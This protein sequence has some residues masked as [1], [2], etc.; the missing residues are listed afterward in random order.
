MRRRRVFVHGEWH[1]WIY[2]CQWQV[3]TVTRLVGHSALQS[4]AKRPILRAA[5]ELDG[6]RLVGMSIDARR[7]TS[8]FAFDLGSRLETHPYDADGQQWLLYE[9]DGR[10]LTYRADGCFTHQPG[11]TPRGQERWRPPDA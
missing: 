10:V 11:D 9:P 7:G 6:Q 1:L 5:Q 8:V 4:A 2:C 3:T